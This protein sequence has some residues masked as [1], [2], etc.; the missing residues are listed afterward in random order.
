MKPIAAPPPQAGDTP[1]P[2]LA[3]L[4][5][6]IGRIEKRQP[7]PRKALSFGIPAVDAVLPGHGLARGALHEIA[8]GGEQAVF[9][10]AP[11]SFTAGIAAR[12]AGQVLWC[13][14]QRDLHAPALSQAG[15]GPDRVIYVDAA[16][17][18][19]VLQAMEEGLRC[20]G[21]GAVVG[22]LSTL[23]MTAS[24]RL[25]L[26][27]ADTGVMAL[28]LRR[29]R[30]ARSADAYGRQPTAATTRWRVTP[31]PS[32]ALPVPGV[33]R[34]VWHVEL[35]RCRGAGARSWIMEA[36]DASG[37]LDLA[38]DLADRS[39]AATVPRRAAAG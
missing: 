35:M 32:R 36:C 12:L 22:E 17:D 39:P 29:W 24:R 15:L 16:G 13:M 10:A 3:S 14:R 33:G 19:Q 25:Q 20:R 2:S 6:E 38:A 37:R 1:Q 26:A 28:A 9:G 31:V 18:Q 21:L 34:P 8:G 30:D 7:G 23:D 4:R 11:T 27:A 5:D